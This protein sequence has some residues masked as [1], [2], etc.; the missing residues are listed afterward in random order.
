MSELV[1]VAVRRLAAACGEDLEADVAA[2]LGSLVVLFGEVG[3]DQPDQGG[4]VGEDH[5]DGGAAADLPVESLLVGSACGAV[6]VSRPVR[7]PRLPTEPNVPVRRL[8]M[9][10]GVVGV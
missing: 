5:D 9:I 4:P 8:F 2:H 7:L 1:S 3:A 6:S 10:E